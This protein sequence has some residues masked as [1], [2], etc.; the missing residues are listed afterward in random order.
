MKSLKTIFL[1]IL[2]II[3]ISEIVVDFVA[4]SSFC[5]P[6]PHNDPEASYYGEGLVLFF[7]LFFIY[8]L[9]IILSSTILCLSCRE[10]SPIVKIVNFVIIFLVRGF[11]ISKLYN[12]Y[13][14]KTVTFAIVRII[15]NFIFMIT[16][17][18]YQI[19]LKINLSLPN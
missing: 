4:L 5:E 8:P 16:S 14:N 7:F 3:F 1:I 18:S 11:I 12:N 10:N 9:L 13:N 17:I 6:E 15:L 2:V 19:I